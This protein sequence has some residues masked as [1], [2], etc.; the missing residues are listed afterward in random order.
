[1]ATASFVAATGLGF[2]LFP[3]DSWA[4]WTHADTSAALGPGRIDN[5]TLLGVLTRW[6]PDP[7]VA[8]MLWYGVA[9][10]VGLAAYWRARQHFLRGEQV[11]AALVV[12]CASTV[13]SPVAWPHYQIWLVLAASWLLIAG[14]RR[15]KILG[16]LMYVPYSALVVLPIF[17]RSFAYGDFPPTLA[18][19][20]LW[21][22]MV[23]VPV[24]ICILGLP[25]RVP[26]AAQ[27]EPSTTPAPDKDTAPVQS[28]AP[29]DV[30]G[31]VV[32]SPAAGR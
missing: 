31:E 6:L 19:R 11:E 21:E 18:L 8:R 5:L 2:L 16:A 26:A 13:I 10:A 4:F 24:L 15:T 27:V 32:P 20:L 25:H 14:A 30:T 17:P 7:A 3:R 9:L 29:A 22:V 28:H 12:G 23:L 1:M